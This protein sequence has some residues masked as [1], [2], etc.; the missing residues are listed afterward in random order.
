M[1]CY[2]H[3]IVANNGRLSNFPDTYATNATHAH[4]KTKMKTTY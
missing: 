4:S 3:V 1:G 2:N